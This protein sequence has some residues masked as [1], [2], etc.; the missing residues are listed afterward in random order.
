LEDTI[1]FFKTLH[2]YQ[3]LGERKNGR[4]KKINHRQ[5]AAQMTK[6]VTFK[7]ALPLSTLG[8]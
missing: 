5:T 8:E 4:R 6:H 3:G 2:A 1:E 7:D